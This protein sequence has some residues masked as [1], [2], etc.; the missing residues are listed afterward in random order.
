MY[1]RPCI[2]AL[3]VLIPSV[4][5]ATDDELAKYQNILKTCYEKAGAGEDI[6]H[7]KGQMAEACKNG[8]E[9]G[10]STLGMVTCTMA[11]TR[12]WDHYLNVEYRSAL[13]GLRDMD[14]D[15]AVHFPEFANRADSLRDAQRAWISFR[16][17]EC[18]LA[19]A[20]W[21]SGSMRNIAASACQLDMTAARILMLKNVGSEM[22]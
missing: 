3:G 10:W 15:E 13:E 2:L 4:A 8:E 19:Y 9:G 5:F 17:A 1:I 14:K 12:A 22:Q 18:G 6:A 21:G 11:E 7:C 16:D 20:L